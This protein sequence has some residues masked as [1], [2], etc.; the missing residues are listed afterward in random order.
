MKP[1]SLT[2]LDFSHSEYQRAFFLGKS[3]EVRNADAAHILEQG[4]F[5]KYAL[6]KVKKTGVFP[7]RHF[8]QFL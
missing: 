6:G 4:R 8:Q 5:T 3:N 2:V 7:D 1:G